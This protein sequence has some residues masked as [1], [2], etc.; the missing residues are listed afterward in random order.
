MVGRLFKCSGWSAAASVVQ[1]DMQGTKFAERSL[2]DAV[3]CFRVDHRLG[4]SNRESASA[5]DVVRSRGGMF[6]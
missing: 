1:N 2:N 4:A 3:S 5:H 6:G